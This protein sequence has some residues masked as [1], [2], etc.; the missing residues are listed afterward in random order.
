M[1]V[2]TETKL[3][4]RACNMIILLH[5]PIGRELVDYEILQ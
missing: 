1:S 3:N 4:L 5:Q 2:K